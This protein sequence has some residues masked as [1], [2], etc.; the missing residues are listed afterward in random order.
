MT[1]SSTRDRAEGTFDEIKGKG[2]QG[3]GEFTDDE[4]M[5]GEGQIDELKGKGE[6]AVGN[7]KDA[8]GD[9][10]DNLGQKDR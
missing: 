10:M 7:V 6:Q 3:L 8:A 9:F 2:K 1:D 4:Q 5:K